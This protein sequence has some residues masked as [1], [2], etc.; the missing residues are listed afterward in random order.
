MVSKVFLN[1]VTSGQQYNIGEK[2]T[3]IPYTYINPSGH[4]R[5]FTDHFT[6]HFYFYFFV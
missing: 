3:F 1:V 2:P 4:S 5:V 6:D